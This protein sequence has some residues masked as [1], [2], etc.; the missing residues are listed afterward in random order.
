MGEILVGNT[1]LKIKNDLKDKITLAIF[2]NRMKKDFG[3]NLIR[4]YC[5]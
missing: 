5:Y 1:S 3:E 2:S 4:L